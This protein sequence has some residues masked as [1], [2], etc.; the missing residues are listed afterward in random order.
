[1]S[2]LIR[3]KTDLG[4]KIKVWIYERCSVK[5]HCLICKKRRWGI[6]YRFMNPRKKDLGICYEC[7]AIIGLGEAIDLDNGDKYGVY[8][9]KKII[10]SA[11]RRPAKNPGPVP[12]KKEVVVKRKYVKKDIKLIDNS[13]PEGKSKVCQTNNQT[14]A[15]KQG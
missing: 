13:I 7:L 6:M 11:P 9:I 10:D 12:Q 3:F 4:E 14:E 2:E 5:H 8:N 1:M 15:Q